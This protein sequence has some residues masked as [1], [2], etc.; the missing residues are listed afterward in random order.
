LA[1]GIQIVLLPNKAISGDARRT[2]WLIIVIDDITAKSTFN[3][4]VVVT[5]TRTISPFGKRAV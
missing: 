4:D 2:A 1:D 5:A 3:N